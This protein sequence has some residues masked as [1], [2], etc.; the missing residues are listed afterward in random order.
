MNSIHHQNLPD[1]PED[2]QYLCQRC[3]NCCRWP[4]FVRLS[5]AEITR[6]SS[7]LGISEFDFIQRYTRLR[8]QRNGL[9]LL[10]NDTNGACIFL[11]GKDCLIQPVKPDQCR[12]FPNGWRFPGWR[13][14][15]HAIPINPTPK[16][17]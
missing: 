15:C 3:T 6:I 1:S 13:S 9:A 11:N 7:Y 17:D 10:D 14:L 8:P 4:G 16:N 5:N 2:V 12:A